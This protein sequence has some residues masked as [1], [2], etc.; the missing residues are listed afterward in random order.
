MIYIYNITNY[1]VYIMFYIIDTYGSFWVA[2]FEKPQLHYILA[3]CR[4][5]SLKPRAESIP[6]FEARFRDYIGIMEKKME[7][8][9]EFHKDYIGVE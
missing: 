6:A 8:T 2:C 7:T 5:A 3:R 9:K 1:I 4:V